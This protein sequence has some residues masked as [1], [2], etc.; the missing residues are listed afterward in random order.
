[1]F[2]FLFQ[3]IEFSPAAIAAFIAM[4]GIL[5]I[6]AQVQK[7]L[8]AILGGFVTELVL[9][10]GCLFFCVDVNRKQT[11]ENTETH[12]NICGSEKIKSVI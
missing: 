11:G 8:A 3:V 2:C 1:M 6:V 5:S 9:T 4:V 12:L 10:S 7:Q